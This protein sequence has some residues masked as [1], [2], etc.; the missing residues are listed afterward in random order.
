ML[1]SI[2]IPKKELNKSEPCLQELY[3][4]QGIWKGIAWQ[5]T[6]RQCPPRS[7]HGIEWS[8][9]TIPSWLAHLLWR[10]AGQEVT[11]RLSMEQFTTLWAPSQL[12]RVSEW[13]LQPG[14]FSFTTIPHPLD[15]GEEYHT[16]SLWSPP[17][18]RVTVSAVCTP[19][20]CH[21]S[22]LSLS[23]GVSNPISFIWLQKGN[24]LN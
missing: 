12:L 14:I 2:A 3:K 20:R 11:S 16:S 23:G 13:W 10:Q 4:K 22:E 21:A 1:L 18:I 7:I 15:F 8:Q 24:N 5:S 19:P 6:L 9:T 17:A